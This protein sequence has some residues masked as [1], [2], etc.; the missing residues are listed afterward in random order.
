MELTVSVKSSEGDFVSV[1]IL[2]NNE[3]PDVNDKTTYQLKTEKGTLLS[4]VMLNV[5]VNDDGDEIMVNTSFDLKSQTFSMVFL[6]QFDEKISLDP[7]F[8]ILLSE[9]DEETSTGGDGGVS[10]TTKIVL[11]VVI[12]TAVTVAIIAV[13]VAVIVSS[14]IFYIRSVSYRRKLSNFNT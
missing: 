4:V 11:I 2:P 12:T 3:N 8:A 13:I 9:T 7:N 14:I 6:S 5:A 1:Q 10:Q